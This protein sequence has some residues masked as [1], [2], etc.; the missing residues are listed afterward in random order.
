LYLWKNGFLKNY[1]KIILY[2]VMSLILKMYNKMRMQKRKYIVLFILSL[3][4]IGTLFLQ[5]VEISSLPAFPGAEGYGSETHGGRGGRIIEVTNLNSSGPGSFREACE[6]SGPR[7]VIFRTGGLINTTKTITIRNPFITIAGQTAPGG[8]ICLGGGGYLSINTHDVIIR[9]IRVRVG[10]NPDGPA[11]DNRDGIGI[12]HDSIPPYNII[13]DHC[14]VSWGIDENIQLW[15]PCHDITIQWCITSEALDSSLNSEGPHSK[16]MII[17]PGAERISIHH[18]L[19][20]HNLERNPLISVDTKT[21][22]INNVIYNWGQ[23]GLNLGNCFPE[24]GEKSDV[25][26]NFFKKGPNSSGLSIEVSKCWINAKVYLKGNIGPGQQKESLDSWDLV[27]NTAGSQIKAS[28]S[29]LESARVTFQ[30]ALEAYELVLKYAGAVIPN[31]DPVDQRIVGDVRNL[32]G[33]IINSQNDVGGWPVYNSGTPPADTDH[34]G[35]PD[36]WEKDHRLD[37]NDYSDCNRTNLNSEGYTN[38]EVYINELMD[39]SFKTTN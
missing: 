14:S 15:Y 19:F 23:R 21:E 31:R 11:G 22:M 39:H 6:A 30:P 32:T 20:A 17:G 28:E 38:I 25:I 34:D 16:G 13:L 4:F 5:Y 10:D 26:S 3:F 33:S 27:Y 37:P 12:N 7:I 29:V 1:F 18:N 8:G 9:N 35:M 36:G 2:R 24:H